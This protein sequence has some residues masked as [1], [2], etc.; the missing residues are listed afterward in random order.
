MPSAYFQAVSFRPTRPFVS[1]AV[2]IALLALLGAPCSAANCPGGVCPTVLPAPVTVRSYQAVQYTA[3]VY[4]STVSV[5]PRPVK[6]GL[7]KKLFGGC[8]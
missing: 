1:A 3:T 8:R 4:R 2:V 5:S 6:Q 7:F